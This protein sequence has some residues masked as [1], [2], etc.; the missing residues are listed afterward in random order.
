MVKSG[1]RALT[2]SATPSKKRATEVKNKAPASTEDKD[3]I[4]N[5]RALG[6]D[7][8]DYKIVKDVDSDDIQEFEGKKINV[9]KFY[10]AFGR[11]YL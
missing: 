10:P 1:R 4:A 3:L 5:I 9:R 11:K 7:E 2:A 6:G 8:E